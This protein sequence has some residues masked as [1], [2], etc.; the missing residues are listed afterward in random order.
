MPLSLWKE[1]SPGRQ[2]PCCSLTNKWIISIRSAAVLNLHYSLQAKGSLQTFQPGHHFVQ[3]HVFY[4]T[5]LKV[6]GSYEG[7]FGCV[8]FAAFLYFPVLQPCY[9]DYPRV[10][11]IFSSAPFCNLLTFIQVNKKKL[12]F[13]FCYSNTNGFFRHHFIVRTFYLP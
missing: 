11:E 12:K 7:L 5:K 1:T 2:T 9:I 8:R 4:N 3:N 10:Y 6:C 13:R